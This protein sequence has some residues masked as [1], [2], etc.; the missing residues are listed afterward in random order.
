MRALLPKFGFTDYDDPMETL[1]QLEQTYSIDV[2]K[3]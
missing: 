2:Y 3:G 1:P